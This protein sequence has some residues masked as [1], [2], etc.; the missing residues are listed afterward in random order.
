MAAKRSITGIGE[1]VRQG[2]KA[3]GYQE[4]GLLSLSSA[5]HSEI[6]AIAKG[7]ADQYEGTNTSLSLPSTRV[8]AFNVEL[9]APAT[10]D[11]AKAIAARIRESGTEGLI[12]VRA[13]GLWLGGRAVAQVSMNIEDHRSVRLADVVAAI[14]SHA[15]LAEA[16]LVGLAPRHAFDGFPADLP[17]RNKRL[18]EDAL[19]ANGFS[20][21]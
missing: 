8:D 4:V 21:D 12:G 13:I 3:T 1:I 7:L 17:V 9:A 15:P 14:E 2:V 10:V 16:E 19:D 11:D 5:D 18:I 6:G 20:A